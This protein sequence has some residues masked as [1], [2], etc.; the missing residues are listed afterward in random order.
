V[1]NAGSAQQVLFLG[2]HVLC[3]LRRMVFAGFRGVCVHTFCIHSPLSGIT[4]AHTCSPFTHTLTHSLSHSPI[5]SFIHFPWVWFR[6]AV[7]LTSSICYR[8]TQN[9]RTPPTDWVTLPACRFSHLV[10]ACASFSLLPVYFSQ[11]SELLSF[12]SPPFFV[13]RLQFKFIL[14]VLHMWKIQQSRGC[15]S[16]KQKEGRI[17]EAVGCSATKWGK[18]RR[19]GQHLAIETITVCKVKRSGFYR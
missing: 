5:H 15:C 17:Y 11:F 6:S 3:S 1:S 8:S 18:A 10:C 19:K 7:M 16:D 2:I 12:I 9:P 13:S 4:Y 14:F